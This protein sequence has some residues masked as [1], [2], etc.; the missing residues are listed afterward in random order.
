MI[1]AVVQRRAWLGWWLSS[2]VRSPD[3]RPVTTPYREQ[4]P[5]VCDESGQHLGLAIGLLDQFEHILE[6]VS[7]ADVN[8]LRE[9]EHE[10][11]TAWESLWDQLGQ[12]RAIATSLGRDT[13]AYD[14]ARAAA[15]DI[16][17]HAAE[18]QISAWQPTVGS[19]GRTLTWRSAP[20]GPAKAA[21]G[22]L[23]RAV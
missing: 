5:R 6:R 16:W 1:V 7:G 18:V 11:R 20:T 9:L 13:K 12:A 21:I 22:A 10:A 4:D 3:T 23:R 17:L 2:A 8:E 14:A 15:G 19:G